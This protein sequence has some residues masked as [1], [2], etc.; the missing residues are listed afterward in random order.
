MR[1]SFRLKYEKNNK[2]Y[3]KT[4]LNPVFSCLSKKCHY[5]KESVLIH[6]MI[7]LNLVYV[8]SLSEAKRC[9][10]KYRECISLKSLCKDSYDT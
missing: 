10:T 7:F 2:F 4:M 9:F 1:L 8:F 3:F 5:F 6:S